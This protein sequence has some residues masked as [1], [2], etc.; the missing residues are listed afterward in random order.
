MLTWFVFRV[1]FPEKTR[2]EVEIYF[3]IVKTMMINI[4]KFTVLGCQTRRLFYQKFFVHVRGLL[5]TSSEKQE[6]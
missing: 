6:D 1:Y 4:K 2:N 3:L 5:C